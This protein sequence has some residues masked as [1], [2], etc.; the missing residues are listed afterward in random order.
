MQLKFIKKSTLNCQ[1]THLK[2]NQGHESMPNSKLDE[3]FLDHLTLLIDYF[4]LKIF[5]LFLA[6]D[7]MQNLR[8]GSCKATKISS[9]L[10]KKK[11]WWEFSSKDLF[12]ICCRWSTSGD[13][14]RAG[15]SSPPCSEDL[16]EILWRCCSIRKTTNFLASTELPLDDFGTSS[17]AFSEAQSNWRK[18]SK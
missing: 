18:V 14:Q 10:F 16:N 3:G 11:S 4:Q 17:A 2:R 15:H 12:D 13:L 9:R 7:S 8:P 6:F 5:I 1:E